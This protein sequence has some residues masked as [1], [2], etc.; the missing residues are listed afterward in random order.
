MMT[1]TPTTKELISMDT[2]P[3]QPI[4]PQQK[5]AWLTLLAYALTHESRRLWIAPL[6]RWIEREVG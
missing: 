1:L 3:H 5:S 4:T 6:T 2:I